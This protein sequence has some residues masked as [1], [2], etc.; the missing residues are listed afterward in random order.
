MSWWIIF[1]TAV[2]VGLFGDVAMK[3]AGMGGVVRWGWLV[4][5]FSAY[6]ATG[7]AW[8]WLLRTRKLSAFGTLYPVANAIGL[9]A[10]GAL[11]FGETLD[12][13]TWLGIAVGC[14]ALWLLS[15][16]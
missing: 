16:R 4:S 9:V 3:Q 14:V 5:G 12:K 8:F 15:E 1:T 11:V 2:I 7:F 13:R 6:T 10:L